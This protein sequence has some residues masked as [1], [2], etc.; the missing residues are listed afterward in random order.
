MTADSALAA[1]ETR[2]WSRAAA[3]AAAAV[4]GLPSQEGF[5]G[6]WSRALLSW[7]D[8]SAGARLL[9]GSVA[10]GIRPGGNRRLSWGGRR[11]SIRKAQAAAQE[12]YRRRREAKGGR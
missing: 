12:T 6:D 8:T 2:F 10:G 11:D 1:R 9:C 5:S 3:V 4:V 7:R